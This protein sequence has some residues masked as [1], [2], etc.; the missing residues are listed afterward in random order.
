MRHVYM[1]DVLTCVS[2]KVEE[3]ISVGGEGGQVQFD[4]WLYVSNEY[5]DRNA[6]K[7]AYQRDHQTEG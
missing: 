7:I 5:I 1:D 3:M 6:N 2:R 4:T